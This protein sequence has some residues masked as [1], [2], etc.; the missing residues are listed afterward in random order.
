MFPPIFNS[1]KS[2]SHCLSK[3]LFAGQ[4]SSAIEYGVAGA[5]CLLNQSQSGCASDGT[6]VFVSFSNFSVPGKEENGGETGAVAYGDSTGYSIIDV[7][8]FKVGDQNFVR[9]SNGMFTNAADLEIVNGHSNTTSSTT[10]RRWNYSFVSG[11][12]ERLKAAVSRLL[13]YI[14]VGGRFLVLIG[15]KGGL[16]VAGWFLLALV[17]KQIDMATDICKRLFRCTGNVNI[18]RWRMELKPTEESKLAK[19][20]EVSAVSLCALYIMFNY[21]W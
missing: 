10:T 2:N 5:K 8:G 13:H 20:M 3:D 6:T 17:M 14:W 18:T 12:G 21:L 19:G 16:L 11:I 15:F 1:T 7:T 9:L 4:N